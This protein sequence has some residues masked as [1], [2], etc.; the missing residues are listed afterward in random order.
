MSKVRRVWE[1]LFKQYEKD[2]SIDMQTVYVDEK[3]GDSDNELEWRCFGELA[4]KV[5][6]TTLSRKNTKGWVLEDMWIY[7]GLP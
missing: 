3:W 1:V 6:D 4:L 5:S 7:E 2:E